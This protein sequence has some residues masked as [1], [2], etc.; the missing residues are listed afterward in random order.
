MLWV[1]PFLAGFVELTGME[2]TY[3]TDTRCT[4]CGTC[5]YVCLSKKI[6]IVDKKPVWQKNIR[7]F[8]CD[9]CLNYCPQ[10][11]VQIKSSPF[12]KFNTEQNGRYSHPYATAED[13]ATQKSYRG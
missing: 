8:N 11:A 12:L 1:G 7:C 3:Y 13:I 10:K 2:N 6:K 9:A 4:G 5:E